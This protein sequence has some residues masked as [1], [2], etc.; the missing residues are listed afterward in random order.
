MEV[1]NAEK[2]PRLLV[3]VTSGLAQSEGEGNTA[4][5]NPDGEG[6]ITLHGH[7]WWICPESLD[8][9]EMEITNTGT[10]PVWYGSSDVRPEGAKPICIETKPAV[11]VLDARVIL[12]DV[13]DNGFRLLEDDGWG[14][15][16]IRC[17]WRVL[18]RSETVVVRVVHERPK[19]QMEIILSGE[20]KECLVPKRWGPL[21]DARRIAQQTFRAGAFWVLFLIGTTSVWVI[22]ALRVI[23]KCHRDK[24]LERILVIPHGITPPATSY[25]RREILLK[26]WLLLCVV[27]LL[28]FLVTL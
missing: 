23:R 11:R 22:A 19:T 7:S 10:K 16:R 26:L 12:G 14:E 3:L 20:L 2:N 21:Q 8:A 17:E 1:F 27:V 28:I 15:G 6:A 13:N 4:T 18:E 9:F 5:K 25:W 24:N